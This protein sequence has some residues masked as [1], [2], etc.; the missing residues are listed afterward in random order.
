MTQRT[1][2]NNEILIRLSNNN[3]DGDRT[4]SDD[5]IKIFEIDLKGDKLSYTDVTDK[6]FEYN[7]TNPPSWYP[8]SWDIH[9]NP[10]S[11]NNTTT[12]QKPFIHI[13]INELKDNKDNTTI[14]PHKKIAQ[15]ALIQIIEHIVSIATLSKE[16]LASCKEHLIEII[17]GDINLIE[18]H[19]DHHIVS[20]GNIENY[21]EYKRI[22]NDK[23]TKIMYPEKKEN[24]NYID[25]LN[26]NPG[27]QI[28]NMI[29]RLYY[30]ESYKGLFLDIIVKIINST[31]Y[32]FPLNVLYPSIVLFP[33]YDESQNKLT[34]STNNSTVISDEKIYDM[35]VS[36]IT[37]NDIAENINGKKF[38]HIVI[39]QDMRI[40]R[41][42]KDK[43]IAYIII[44]NPQKILT[45]ALNYFALKKFDND[46]KKMHNTFLTKS[47]VDYVDFSN[48]LAN[49]A[50][51]NFTNKQKIIEYFNVAKTDK[52]YETNEEFKRNVD[53][54]METIKNN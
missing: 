31:L 51:N 16:T 2:S 27:L 39:W 1:E 32:I 21:Q 42:D 47:K 37:E 44:Y 48:T 25:F 36:D 14:S 9:H 26:S 15:R 50:S 35:L 8:S 28:N 54:I 3:L 7:K 18:L 43:Y 22:L 45:N 49:F 53:V 34:F 40:Q 19:F 17:G 6:P 33:N 30:S 52:L 24:Y 11:T 12:T 20:R 5:N 4:S 46:N 41:E 13:L 38:A 23:S 10:Q 29:V